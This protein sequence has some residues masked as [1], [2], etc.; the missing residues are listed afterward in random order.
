MYRLTSNWRATKSGTFSTV[1][2]SLLIDNF[3]EN[4]G[5]NSEVVMFV[6]NNI[7]FT[8]AT[9]I[10]ATSISGGI[11]T[12]SNVSIAN[13]D[14]L[15]FGIAQSNPNTLLPGGVST[16]LNT[17]FWYQA[18]DLDLAANDKV[19]SWINKGQNGFAYRNCGP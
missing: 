17:R 5:D 2:F 12:F 8:G 15:S 11:A 13:G 18:E 3:N 19:S 1:D 9:I 6:S 10:N 14:F 7:S 16:S 4:V